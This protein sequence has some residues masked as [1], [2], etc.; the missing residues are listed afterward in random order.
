MKKNILML[1]NGFGIEQTDSYN[2]YSE[3]L[4]PNMDKLTKIG[5]FGSINSNDLDYKTGYRKFSIG[6]SEDLSYSIVS[7]ALYDESYKKN[8][9]FKFLLTDLNGNSKKIHI[10]CYW[11]NPSTI[12][13]LIVYIKEIIANASATIFVHLILNQQSLKDYKDIERDLNTLNY[14]FGSR[15]K[16]GIVSG[17][18][19][20]NL[21]KDFIKMLVNESGER[22]TDIGKRI[23]TS[24]D[25]RT[26]P[27][28]MRMFCLNNGYKLTDNDSILFYNYSNIDISP[29][30]EELI[31]AKN[32]AINIGTIKFYSLF[33]LVCK[34]VN[35]PYLYNYGVSSTY[36]LNSLKSINAK[37]LV[38]AKKDYCQDINYYM[39]GLRGTFDN[40]L[41]YMPTDNEFIYDGNTLINTISN[42]QQELI[43][44]NYEIDDAKNVEELKGKLSKIDTVIGYLYNYAIQNNVGLFIS[45]LYGIEKEMYNNKHELCKINFSVRAPVIIID[46][47]ISKSNYSLGVGTVYDLSNSIIK[48]IN[49]LYKNSGLLKKKN[50]VMSIFYKK[51]N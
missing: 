33:P 49:S 38:M 3:S 6:I 36:I 31:N 43:I 30:I 40:D 28:N 18:R 1:I 20:T 14:E 48:N 9:V 21:E 29:Y 4:M 27:M 22:W 34:N 7:N 42:L 50:G 5:L 10:I 47:N 26:K 13:Q 2:I 35:I 15:V 32:T 11:D 23:E 51:G 46:K 19:I 39:T 41:K 44:I 8:D 12:Q 45:S 37:C 25:T 24:I 17:S 16:T